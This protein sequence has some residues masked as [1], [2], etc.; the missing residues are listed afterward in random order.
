MGR[1]H[2]RLATL[3]GPA[4]VWRFGPHEYGW[5]DAGADSRPLRS[6]APG[7]VRVGRRPVVIHA[8]GQSVIVAV[9]A[10]H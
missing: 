3:T 2:G 7:R 4:E 8:P 5:L 1:R 9:L 10:G 6:E